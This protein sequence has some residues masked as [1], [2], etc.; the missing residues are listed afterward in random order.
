MSAS[1]SGRS[2]TL[3]KL[4]SAQDLLERAQ[5]C[6]QGQNLER[7]FVLYVEA[8]RALLACS[9][10]PGADSTALRQSAQRCI[11]RAQK[12]K[13]IRPEVRAEW[14][15]RLREDEQARILKGSRQYGEHV[16]PIWSDQRTNDALPSPQ[17]S[18]RHLERQATYSSLSQLSHTHT[19]VPLRGWHVQQDSVTDCSV[20]AS[21]AC[22]AEYN[23]RWQ[24]SLLQDQ[25]F[26][27]PGGLYDVRLF[28]NGLW[29][30]VT[31]NDQ[32]PCSGDGTLLCAQASSETWPT[33]M[34]KA[35]LSTQPG[36]Y[37]FAGSNS[38]IDLT[39]LLGWIPERFVLSAADFRPESTW[40][41]LLSGFERGTC[42]ITAGTGKTV[43]EYDV[44]V[45]TAQHDYSVFS[46]D[47]RDGQ[48][49]VT[50]YNPWR[51]TADSELDRCFTMSFEDVCAYFDV[52]YVNWRPDESLYLN[53]VHLTLTPKEH[54]T[55]LYLQ[56]ESQ[57][58]NPGSITVVYLRH[59]KESDPPQPPF[60]SV[61]LLSEQQAV[62]DLAAREY[63]DSP[64]LCCHT[65]DSTPEPMLVLL[66]HAEVTTVLTLTLQVYSAFKL[67][68]VDRPPDKPITSSVDGAWEGLTAGGNPEYPTWMNNPQYSLRIQE[69]KSCDFCFSLRAPRANAV[70]IVLARHKGDRITELTPDIVVADSGAYQHGI[71]LCEKSDLRPGSYAL[72]VSTFGQGQEASFEITV[73]G[74]VSCELVPIPREGA[75]MF[76]RSFVSRWADRPRYRL[77]ILQP[78]SVL[79][80]TQANDTKSS[81]GISMQL[82]DH[83]GSECATAR[84]S[85]GPSGASLEKQL[86]PGEYTLLPLCRRADGQFKLYVYSNKQIN[87]AML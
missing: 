20:V 86:Q 1:S 67:S 77:K 21:L 59:R 3:S 84:A 70:H 2:P 18:A 85:S 19:K 32:M 45:L 61:G 41:R 63:T 64:V 39:A 49:Q 79:L 60:A 24:K 8:G 33:L 22:C 48:R 42:L 34:E 55:R 75:G 66:S 81:T 5:K 57:T 47:D 40:K 7:A 58:M 35:Y 13:A 31:I 29:R 52:I 43:P 53:T 30:C 36:G 74:T 9:D 17:L 82:I 28:L 11:G 15:S 38:N 4:E 76:S 87:A 78:T 80:R 25:V 10:L 83:R 73:E 26:K 68:I 44:Q 72:I 23:Y 56:P 6:E 12:I 51:T 62:R 71:A 65:H 14:S 54:L 69:K 27:R 37:E 16:L 46:L 50:L